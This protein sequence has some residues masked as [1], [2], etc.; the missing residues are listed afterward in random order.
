MTQPTLN[1]LIDKYGCENCRGGCVACGQ[2]GLFAALKRAVEA[3]EPLQ[4][5]HEH[6][7]ICTEYRP[8]G[9]TY[10][11]CSICQTKVGLN[12][13]DARDALADIRKILEGGGE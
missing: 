1:E 8:L 11:W 7:E 3:L 5:G 12:E 2:Y 6:N 10:G 13:D 9:N 4:L